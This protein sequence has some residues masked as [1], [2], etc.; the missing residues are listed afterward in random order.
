MYIST[1]DRQDCL[2]SVSAMIGSLSGYCQRLCSP[3]MT[4][5]LFLCSAMALAVG[6]RPTFVVTTWKSIALFFSHLSGVMDCEKLNGELYVTLSL[7]LTTFFTALLTLLNITPIMNLHRQVKTMTNMQHTWCD[8]L[9]SDNWSYRLLTLACAYNSL[10][11]SVLTTGIVVT[12]VSLANDDSNDL[13]I[14]DL[15]V[16]PALLISVLLLAFGVFISYFAANITIKK[17]Q[18]RGLVDNQGKKTKNLH[19]EIMLALQEIYKTWSNMGHVF[20]LLAYR[21]FL[22]IEGANVLIKVTNIDL[23]SGGFLRFFSLFFGV[24]FTLATTITTEFQPKPINSVAEL[25]SDTEN[26]VEAQQLV[27]VEPVVRPS[28]SLCYNDQMSFRKNSTLI[29]ICFARILIVLGG[30][31]PDDASVPLS[32]C[33]GNPLAVLVEVLIALMAFA[34]AIR[35]CVWEHAQYDLR[36]AIASLEGLFNC[37]GSATD[38]GTFSSLLREGL[39]ESGIVDFSIFSGSTEASYLPQL[40]SRLTS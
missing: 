18:C 20:C 31:V 17:H 37:R 33:S 9:L 27:I 4:H 22:W 14:K 7:C 6:S 1:P 24:F 28:A 15:F 13:P 26:N 40:N 16:K 2:S 5:S 32:I 30:N 21:G 19:D 38:H 39:V 11:T 29:L 34:F 25:H 10:L 12:W 23:T 35:Y 8:M 3:K 36:L